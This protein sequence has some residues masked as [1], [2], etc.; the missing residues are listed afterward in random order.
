MQAG[1]NISQRMLS[2]QVFA[3]TGAV[4]SK[5]IPRNGRRPDVALVGPL[6]VGRCS[7]A[8]S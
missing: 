6:Y 1:I 4:C 2:S 7:A 8:R 3:T 5:S